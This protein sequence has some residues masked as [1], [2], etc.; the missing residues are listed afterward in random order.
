MQWCKRDRV[1]SNLANPWIRPILLYRWADVIQSLLKTIQAYFEKSMYP[2]TRRSIRSSSVM[3]HPN[4]GVFLYTFALD[5]GAYLHPRVC[6]MDHP[7]GCAPTLWVYSVR[8]SSVQRQDTTINSVSLR[9]WKRY[10]CIMSGLLCSNKCRL[11]S[12]LFMPI[13]RITRG[14]AIAE[15]P[16]DALCQLKCCRLVHNCRQNR[17]LNGL[18]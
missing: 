8:S 7:C 11:E 1:R 2:N 6:N 4:C 17:I 3:P 9:G 16:R 14:S 5:D 12:L 15:G 13:A 10:N 18:Q